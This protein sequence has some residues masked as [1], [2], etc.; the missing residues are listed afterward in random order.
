MLYDATVFS[1]NGESSCASCHIFG[2]LDDLA[3]DL[4]NPDEVVT[5]NPMTIN[6]GEP[7]A[8]TIG[9]G[10]FNFRG[11][12]N[13]TGDPN[14]FHP[15]K[16]PMTT[17][18]LRGLRNSG[19]MHWRGDRANGA[20][21]V[22]ATDE[23]LSFNN[24]TVAFP[25]LVGSPMEPPVA[26]MEAFTDFQLQVLLP[27]NPV[28][29][30][31]NSLT[32]A[33]EAGRTFY[34]GPRAADGLNVPIVGD[35]S[36]VFEGFTCKGCHELDPAQGE[37]G[38]S[39]DGAFEGIISQIFKVPHLRNLYTKVGMFGAP[40]VDSFDAPDTGPTGDQIRG[41]GFT[42]DGTVDT[43][44]RFFTAAVFRPLPLSGFPLVNPD[45]TRRDVEQ[46]MLAFDSDLAPIVGQQVTLTST[47]GDVVAPRIDLLMQRAG[48][49]FTSKVLGGTVKEC[50]LVANVVDAGTM[51]GFLYD[52]G[53]GNFVP[54]EGGTPISDAALRGRAAT[55][56]Q[57]VTYTCVPPGSGPRIA[58][59]Q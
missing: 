6:L 11:D 25:G 12:I 55:P 14:V 38:T 54:G 31:D 4:G 19:A 48:A 58:S 22:D 15:M 21:G 16:G 2:D 10:L 47:N 52:P 23:V 43:I 13:G 50:D 17:Q 33:Q 1:G 20:F 39:K 28:R 56:G 29:N 34:F 18:T 3:W 53:A 42:N 32:Q 49:S 8:I 35:V 57:E 59:G 26:D 41:F 5:D 24:F 51:R 46:F 45:E 7:L 9:K 27:P 44:F 40:K 37:F 36:T 30:L